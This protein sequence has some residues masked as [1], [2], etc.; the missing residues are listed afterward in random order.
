MEETDLVGTDLRGYN[1]V[2]IRDC[3]LGIEGSETFEE[4]RLTKS[5]IRMIEQQTGFSTT[6]AA[7]LTA[8]QVLSPA[9]HRPTLPRQT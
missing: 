5:A 8:C 4:S 7:V 2:L 3:T 6:S 1:V 9:E